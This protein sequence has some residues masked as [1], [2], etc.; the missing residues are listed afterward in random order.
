M[1]PHTKY[2]EHR[3]INPRDPRGITSKYD[4][5]SSDSLSQRIRNDL[6]QP[7]IQDI[8]AFAQSVKDSNQQ[9]LSNVPLS[10]IVESVIDT[11]KVD[12]SKAR[13]RPEDRAADLLVPTYN[14]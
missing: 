2:M 7:L 5:F 6:S 11:I 8:Y 14:A 12:L 1:F 9:K 4:L 3:L 13:I 10:A